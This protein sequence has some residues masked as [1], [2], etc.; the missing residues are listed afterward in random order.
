MNKTSLEK[1]ER[2]RA[3]IIESREINEKLYNKLV[4]ELGLKGYSTDEDLLFDAVWNTST[5]SDF[6]RIMQNIKL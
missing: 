5:Q 1:I 4:E 2:V 6:E 3:R